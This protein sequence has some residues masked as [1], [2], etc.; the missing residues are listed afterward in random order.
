MGG[1]QGEVRIGGQAWVRPTR[2]QI[3]IRR[4]MGRRLKNFLGGGR[5]RADL[6]ERK[7]LLLSPS[8]QKR[9]G[10]IGRRTK[11][12]ASGNEMPDL[13]QHRSSRA[14]KYLQIRTVTWRPMG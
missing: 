6:Q 11:A 7:S 4:G 12:G 10:T 1:R 2:G 8:V 14:E 3:R 9:A 13:R 5:A